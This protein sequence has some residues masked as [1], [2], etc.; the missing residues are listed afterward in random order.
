MIEY[1]IINQSQEEVFRL[2]QDYK[3][4]LDW[5]PF[6]ESYKFLNGSVLEVGL[7]L[8]VVDK[9]GRA[10]VVEY[11]SYKPPLVAAVKMISGP[12]YIRSFAG[13]WSF[14]KLSKNETIAVFKYNIKPQLP[15]IGFILRWVFKRNIA[16][17]LSALKYYAES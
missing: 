12:W 4:R 11:I 16:K 5:D 17:R 3:L 2:S 8:K 13:S 7:R 9:A 14:K 10:M 6:P 15:I 1:K